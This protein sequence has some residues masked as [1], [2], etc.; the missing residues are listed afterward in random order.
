MT[1]P[2][3]KIRDIKVVRQYYIN[4]INLLVEIDFPKRTMSFV[5]VDSGAVSGYNPKRWLFAKREPEY[6]KTWAK[7]FDAQKQAT[8]LVIKELEEVKEAD[9]KA[10]ALALAR[11]RE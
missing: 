5:E 2:L 8:L 1:A 3:A 4:G 11:E 7:I 9:L 10:L 6:L